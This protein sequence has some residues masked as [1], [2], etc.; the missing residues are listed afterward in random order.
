MNINV[1]F[2]DKERPKHKHKFYEILIYTDGSGVLSLND[3]KVPFSP[4]TIVI[5]PPN[6]EHEAFSKDTVQRIF[7]N[8]SFDWLLTNSDPVVLF[9]NSEGDG[10]LLADL[11]YR[12]RFENSDYITSLVSA[13]VN[14]IFHNADV[15]NKMNMAVKSIANEISKRFCDSE[16]NPT[17]I[18]AKSGYAED[19]VRSEFKK[20]IGK[21]PKA[22]LI[23]T[24]VSHSCL[25]IDMYKNSISLTKIAE[26][27]GFTDYV[28]FSRC[29]KKIT[30]MSPR[31]YLH[32]SQ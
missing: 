11:I 21:S 15:D 18:L 3:V 14:Y 24:R 25:L 32:A 8:G 10:L 30:G 17:E 12:G 9:G 5:I 7:I 26:K 13:L 27:C 6:T 28:Y 31:E 16:L 4:G 19:Y 2:L 23:E 22:F 29:F 20:I 1:G